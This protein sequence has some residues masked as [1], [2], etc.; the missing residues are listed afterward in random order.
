M[1]RAIWSGTISFGLVSVPVKVFTAVREHTVHFHQL[2]R[3]TGSRI[4]YQKVSERSGQE[5]PADQIE[6]G[7]ELSKNQLVTVDPDQID[8]LRP[9]STRTI[10]IVDFVDLADIDPAFY[11]KTYWLGPD[12]EAARRPYALLAAAMID[13]HQAGIGTLV[14]RNKQYLAAVRPRDDVLALSTMHFADELVSPSDVDFLPSKGRAPEPKELRLATQLIDSLRT[15]WDPR[16]YRDDYT[17]E[18]KDL[19]K[20]QAAGQQIVVEESPAQDA[21]VLDLMTALEASLQAVS[22]RGQSRASREKKMEEAAG[23]ARQDPAP[24]GRE[25]GTT[26]TKK[27]AS[28]GVKPKAGTSS[29]SG[30]RQSRPRKSA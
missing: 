27:S 24:E 9:R 16:R 22:N 12:G 15:E 3:S 21:K 26:A 11:H 18:V 6:L 29:K 23:R 13:R 20:R 2:E 14:L 28:S 30:H 10:E 5:V 4:R 19:I 1:P 7:Y 25:K 17:D 8:E